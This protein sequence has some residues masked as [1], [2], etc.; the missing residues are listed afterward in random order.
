MVN[1]WLNSTE[2]K[3]LFN[4]IRKGNLDTVK[5]LVECGYDLSNN[6][7]H[8]LH[9]AAEC[10][11]LNIISYL[12]EQGLEDKGNLAL[13]I[14]LY[15]R[16][17][18]AARYLIK[19]GSKVNDM[20]FTCMRYAAIKGHLD[21]VELLVENGV[22]IGVGIMAA[23][24][25]DQLETLKCLYNMRG[26]H[27]KVEEVQCAVL[28][29]HRD[30]IDYMRS[31]GH[32][33]YMLEYAI[34]NNRLGTTMYLFEKCRKRWIEPE[35][36]RHASGHDYEEIVRYLIGVGIDPALFCRKNHVIGPKV[37]IY[38]RSLGIIC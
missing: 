21:T 27:F 38:F 23:I 32:S 30:I 25:Y 8:T 29:E 17:L 37:S 6:G 2:T 12:T 15:H 34:R 10:G 3:I 20:G 4:A 19:V 35:T 33:Y 1:R 24:E 16:R 36:L 7:H 11:N 31:L 13:R 18:D 5:D 9:H 14:A 22:D 28:A 26:S